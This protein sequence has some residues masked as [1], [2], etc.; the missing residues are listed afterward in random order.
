MRFSGNFREVPIVR[1][2][3]EG[4]GRLGGSREPAEDKQQHAPILADNDNASK[5]PCDAPGVVFGVAVH[6]MRCPQ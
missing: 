3:T 1:R 5:Q 2:P 6:A 4:A